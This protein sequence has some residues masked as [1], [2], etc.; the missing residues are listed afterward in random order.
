[1]AK[2]YFTGLRADQF[3][4]PLDLEATHT[5]QKLPGLDL[6]VR[7][8]LGSMAEQV[9]QLNNLASSIRLGDRQ[10]PHIYQ[11]LKDACGILD[12]DV[13]ELYIQQNPTPNAYTFAMRGQQ[14]FMVIHTSLIEILTEA[15]LQAVMA[16]ELGHLKC[17]HG[18]YL[19]MANLLMLATNA[20]PMW[21][22]VLAQSIQ[23][24]MMEWLRCAELS[25]DRAAF[26]VSQD[27]KIVMSVLMKL[28]GGSPTLA[29]LLN[30]EAFMEQAKAYEHLSQSQL[31]EALRS[32]QSSQ[33]THPVPVIRAQEVW[34]WADS[35]EYSLLLQPETLQYNQKASSAGGWRNW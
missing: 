34:R 1:M 8:L 16:H 29:P 19:T 12:L 15:E 24:K 17:E 6:T 35:Q 13:P 4:H 18:V 23:E 5:L 28:A 3:R 9:F 14:P 10:L 26:L 27:P 32:I 30:L 25:C 21:G 31:G 22:A 2:H 20:L 33:L 7:S 11:L